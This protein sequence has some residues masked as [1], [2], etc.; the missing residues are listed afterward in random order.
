MGD[1]SKPSCSLST[2]CGGN[3]KGIQKNLA[4]LKSLGISAIWISPIVENIEGAYH[5]YWASNIYNINPHFGTEQDLKDLI[6]AAHSMDIWIMVDVVANH[7][8]L[9]GDDF[10]KIFPFNKPEHYHSKCQINQEDF[11]KNQW[12]VEVFHLNLL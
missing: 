4:Y 6:A 10:S 5:G 2:Y 1:G 12:R 3:F 11:T 7:V 9:V 8:G